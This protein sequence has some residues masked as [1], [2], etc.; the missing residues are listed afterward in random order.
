MRSASTVRARDRRPAW[1]DVQARSGRAVMLADARGAHRSAALP[2]P[3]TKGKSVGWFPSSRNAMSSLTRRIGSPPSKPKASGDYAPV[4]NDNG[5][6]P[7]P[8]DNTRPWDEPVGAPA[9]DGQTPS[10]EPATT[11]AKLGARRSP[12]QVPAIQLQTGG[13]PSAL[14]GIVLSRACW[15]LVALGVGWSI[16][17]GFGIAVKFHHHAPPSAP[18]IPPQAPP[19]P[20]LPPPPPCSPPPPPPPPA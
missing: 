2:P 20:P 8:L 16:L 3:S 9:G 19:P 10:S 15:F 7:D 18:P 1:P 4:S 13:V 17:S 11:D 14:V 6:P 12:S 5:E